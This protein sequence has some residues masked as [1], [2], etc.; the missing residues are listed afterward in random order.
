MIISFGEVLIDGLP[1]GDVVGGAPLN[2]VVHLKQLGIHSAIITKIGKDK[3]GEKIK[4]LMNVKAVDS[5]LQEDETL[6][7]GYVEV[8]LNNGIPSYSILR[9]KAWEYI[10]EVNLNQSIEYLVFGS[11]AMISNHN[12]RVFENIRQKNP[13]TT[14]ICDINLRAPLYNS[15]SIDFCLRNTDILKINDEELDYLAS[16]SK[17][18]SPIDWLD[19]KYRI[20]KI[21]LTK[22]EKGAELFW[23][24]EHIQTSAAKI[25]KMQDT[26][27]AGD[28]FLAYFIY[29][30]ARNF[31]LIEVLQKA[32][33][34]A[35]KICEIK[36]AI[37]TNAN[38]YNTFK[39][40][41]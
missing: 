4:Q 21:I 33:E 22:G 6:S 35:S 17:T 10:N 36:G 15:T 25:T 41:S 32:S 11:L 5:L 28:G 29:G 12:Q 20:N 16:L 30:M 3:H 7:T 31:P 19:N 13:S 8:K 14:T 9:N 26:I 18:S 38:F 24:G 40:Q 39:I 34:F 2:I 23:N 37:P 1:D 27:G